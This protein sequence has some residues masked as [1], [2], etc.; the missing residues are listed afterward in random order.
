[1]MKMKG[2]G[3]CKVAEPFISIFKIIYFILRTKPILINTNNSI[4][5]I[6][7]P[8]RVLPGRLSVARAFGDI[9]AK[10]PKYNGNPNV[11]IAIPEITHFKIENHHD[12]IAI[13]C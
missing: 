13:G 8:L 5:T 6:V 9:H 7:G 3:F 2:K 4:E 12:F 1:M 11:V 10:L